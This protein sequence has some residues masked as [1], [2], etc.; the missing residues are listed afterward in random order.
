MP[1]MPNMPQR[2]ENP[3]GIVAHIIVNDATAAMDFYKKAF[4]AEELMR[5]PAQDGKRIMH[6]EM[7]IG[8]SVFYLNDDFPEFCGGKERSPKALG[9]TPI[10]LHQYVR[11]CD[12]AMKRFADAGGKITMPAQDMFWGDRY[13]Q[14]TDPFG[15]VWSFATPLKK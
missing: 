8:P 2:P 4:G 10:V 1:E 7:K 13:G 5:M 6:A 14:A 15:H 3:V 9:N 11:D 12:A